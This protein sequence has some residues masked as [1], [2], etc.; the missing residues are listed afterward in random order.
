[1]Q[2]LPNAFPN[3]LNSSLVLEE[4]QLFCSKYIK[5]LWP[6]VMQLFPLN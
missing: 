6:I 5:V 4:S 2:N 3:P 1:M